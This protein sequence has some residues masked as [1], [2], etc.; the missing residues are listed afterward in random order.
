MSKEYVFEFTISGKISIVADSDEEAQ[1]KAEELIANEAHG[2]DTHDGFDDLD[3]L[4]G[5]L[6]SISEKE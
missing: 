5:T 1:E 4:H 3:F 6:Y 2:Y